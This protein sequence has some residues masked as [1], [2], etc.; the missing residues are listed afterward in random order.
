MSRKQV[1][2][3]GVLAALV[4]AV[5]WLARSNRQPPFLPQD[6]DHASF[7]GAEPCLKCHGPDGPY[8][9]SRSHPTGFDC[10][11]CHGRR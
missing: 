10:I 9:Q 11:R 7:D 6:G 2:L 5:V 1:V 8:P 3:L 4:L